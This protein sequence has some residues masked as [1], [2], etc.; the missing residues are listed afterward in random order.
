[1]HVSSWIAGLACVGTQEEGF[2]G[3]EASSWSDGVVSVGVGEVHLSV[4]DLGYGA[5]CAVLEVLDRVFGLPA[6]GMR[7][8]VV[9]LYHFVDAYT[10]GSLLAGAPKVGGEKFKVSVRFCLNSTQGDVCLIELIR[11]Y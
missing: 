5:H 1:M 4:E 9:K 2:V 3:E 7:F 11:L 10:E 6:E 8:I